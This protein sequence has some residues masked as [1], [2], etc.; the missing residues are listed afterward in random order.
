MPDVRTR[1]SL[2]IVA[3]FT[4]GLK[5]CDLS[6][7]SHREACYRSLWLAVVTILEYKPPV[8]EEY[9][10]AL[11]SAAIGEGLRP[12][13]VDSRIEFAREVTA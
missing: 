13:S 8:V 2:E 4:R 11:R 3:A 7:A 10:S 5:Q 12:C 9:I 6:D 1:R